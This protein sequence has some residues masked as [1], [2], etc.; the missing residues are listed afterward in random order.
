[1]RPAKEGLGGWIGDS[2]ATLQRQSLLRAAKVTVGK[3]KVYPRLEGQYTGGSKKQG[4]G[5][6]AKRIKGQTE[7]VA[8]MQLS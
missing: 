8:K 5:L 6:L 3:K 1:M 4:Q 2:R 7:T